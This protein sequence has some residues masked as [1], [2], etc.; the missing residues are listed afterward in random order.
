MNR[1][2]ALLC[3]C[4]ALT[5]VGF[6][7]DLPAP[8]APATARVL[9]PKLSLTPDHSNWTY[10]CGESVNFL[11]ALT[12]DGAPLSNASVIYRF[13]PESVT[14]DDLANLSV[15]DIPEMGALNRG[16]ATIGADGRAAIPAGTLRAPGFLRCIATVEHAGR[17]Y[18]AVAT[19][20]F[21]PENIH[22]TQTEPAD[23]D[24]YWKSALDELAKLPVEPQ[25]TLLPE[26]CTDKVD[27]YHVRL[28]NVAVVGMPRT[29][30]IFGIL[31]EP[32]GPGP[33]PA[34]LYVPG[35]GVRPY[36]GQREMA[37]HGII[38]FEIG[39]HGVPVILAPEVY[40]QLNTSATALYYLNNLD[41]RDR[42]YYRRVYLGCVRA[43]DFLCQ[44]PK[45]DG[46][47]LL[48][49]GGSQGGQLSI[50][51]A[52]LDPRVKAIAAT[53]PAYCDLTGYLHG[54]AGGW[55]HPFRAD[56]KQNRTDAKIKATSYYDTVN[57]ARRIRVPGYYIW[58]YNDETCPPTSMFAAYN[59]ITAPK[60]LGL[61]LDSGHAFYR[62]Q[63]EAST[64]W[65]VNFLGLK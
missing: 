12:S 2:F 41:D 51:T 7:A 47:N 27:V 21:E 9:A 57:F 20:G 49:T 36:R 8:P 55:P 13:G 59:A 43:N 30:S 26:L 58:G 61:L 35:A 42:I 33:Y 54:R 22:P 32:K 65:L 60:Q 11:V 19:A 37:E 16:T 3:V 34:I 31:C 28:Q 50:V 62:E 18:R 17:T 6:S 10:R 53:Y 4:C 39:I 38:T 44:R 25:L 56:R 45:F 15:S 29:S 52:T 5:W 64:M 63:A 1:R 23:F 24:A 48:V 14:A 40:D 46:R